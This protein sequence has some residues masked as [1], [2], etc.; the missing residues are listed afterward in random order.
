MTDDAEVVVAART[1]TYLL[2]LLPVEK[3]AAALEIATQ[4]ELTEGAKRATRG[5]FRIIPVPELMADPTG[6]DYWNEFIQFE[7]RLIYLFTRNITNSHGRQE[8][9][10]LLFQ[11]HRNCPGSGCLWDYINGLV[12]ADA[13]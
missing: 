1:I 8:A 11:Q 3:R 13:A 7:A 6:S 2:N 5:H 12:P 10:R 4:A 9:A